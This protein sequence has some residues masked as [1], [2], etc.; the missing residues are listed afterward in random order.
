MVKRF[1]IINFKGGVGKTTLAFNVA[2]KLSKTDGSRVLLC[3]VDHQSS[4]S[5]VCMRRRKWDEAV[6]QHKTINRVFTHMTKSGQPMPGREIIH[7]PHPGLERLY[8]T[9]DIVPSELALDETE[10]D[11]SGTTVGNAVESDWR[12]RTLI[13]EWLETNG[14]HRDYEYIIF[15]CPPATKIVTQNALAASHGYLVPTI[16]DAVSVRGTPHLT[17]QMMS[18]IEDQLRDYSGLL[19]TKGYK[20][21]S[22]YVPT[23]AFIG[24]V[25][26]RIQT[27]RGASGWTNDATENLAALRG[28]Y[29]GNEIIEPLIKDGVGVSESLTRGFPVYH[30]PREQNIGGQ[31][32]PRVFS[33]VT[34][35]IKRRVDAI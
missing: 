9:L 23:R 26:T 34:A 16:P 22:T 24:I 13:C 6:E 2:C 21:V 20:L 15:D 4:L 19:R 27:S 30:Y 28:Q 29:P 25:I 5:I 1:S 35:E 18:K 7:K 11:L 3:D 14:I 17:N 33:E 8:P 12:R 10:I 31:G 32:F